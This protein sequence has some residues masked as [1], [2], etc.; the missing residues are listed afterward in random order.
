MI[1]PRRSTIPTAEAASADPSMVVTVHI[2]Q[3][4]R[5]QVPAA[6]LAVAAHRRVLRAVPG[7]TFSKLLGTSTGFGHR[8]ADLSRWVLLTCW[9]SPV[10]ASSF[11]EHH[12]CRAWRDR[13][14]ETWTATLRPLSAHGRWS[15]Q[16][17]FGPGIVPGAGAHRDTAAA[18]DSAAGGPVLA[19]TRA[20]LATRHAVTFWRAVPRVAEDLAGRRGLRLG[21]GIG[22]A[23]IGVQGTLS[24]WDDAAALREFAFDG[25]P[26]R[27]A[28]ARTRELGW[29]AEEIFARFAVIDS[30]GSVDGLD[31]VRDRPSGSVAA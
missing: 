18:G 21:F 25:E 14:T 26:H 10:P 22:E 13:A 5:G 2:W 3:L 15:G 28:I 30:G 8:Q 31:P 20:R 11:E 19:V 27:H 9:A 7:V 1:V 4:R 16:Q 12:I 6:L 29:Y 17:P 24:I 23:P